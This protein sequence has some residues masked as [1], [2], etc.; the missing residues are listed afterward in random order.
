MP[1]RFHN[2]SGS[3]KY[4]P[5]SYPGPGGYDDRYG[6]NE[7]RNGYGYGRESDGGYRYGEERYGRDQDDEYRGRRSVDGDSY[8]RRS[9]SSDRD[10]ERAYEDDGPY[11]SRESNGK[12]E[13]QSHDGRQFGQKSPEQN[14]GV[15][16]SYE[17]AVA[18]GRS[19]I[20]RDGETKSVSPPPVTTTHETTVSSTPPVAPAVAP[21]PVAATPP[22]AVTPNNETNGF[23][24]F[25]PRGSFGSFPVI[26]HT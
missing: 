20:E 23:D 25:D 10:R 5:G 16:P 22:P 8:S 19:P 1:T 18:G 11:S 2:T 3:G 7:D 21:S 17:D 13:D 26:L 6:S 24:E 15:P 14:L 4:R 12:G 9:R